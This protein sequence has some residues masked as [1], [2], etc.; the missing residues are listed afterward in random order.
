MSKKTPAPIDTSLGTAAYQL[1]V[2]HQA[3]L[4]PRLPAGT[5]TDLA[6]DLTL[7]GASPNPPPPPAAG[8]AP[9][10]PPPTL[11]ELV[12]DAVAITSGIHDAI[13]GAK[14]TAAVRK[15]YGVSSNV[16]TTEP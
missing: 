10:P 1:A 11:A 16:A 9:P 7:L 2:A 8:A 3:D 15:A 12:A 4:S 6:A 14:A 13:H 5:I